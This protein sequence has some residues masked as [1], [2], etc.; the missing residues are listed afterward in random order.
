MCLSTCVR[1]LA[2]VLLLLPALRAAQV[3]AVPLQT[4]SH[5][6]LLK[7]VA[8]DPLTE[9]ATP[10]A[11]LR[12][13]PPLDPAT[14]DYFFVQFRA[15][16]TPDDRALLE[17][18]GVEIQDYVPHDAYL[19]RGSGAQRQALQRAAAVRASADFHPWYRLEPGLE[20]RVLEQGLTEV[21]VFLF[22]GADSEEATLQMVAAGMQ[23][24]EWDAALRDRM[25]VLVDAEQLVQLAHLRDVQWVQRQAEAVLRNDQASWVLQSNQ[26][27]MTP[28][29]DQ[30][31]RGENMIVGHIDGGV[32]MDSCYFRDPAVTTPGPTHR[33]MVNFRGSM[34][35]DTHGTHTAGTA[36]GDREPIAGSTLNNGIA[37]HARMTHTNLSLINTINLFDSLEDQFNDGALVF[38]NSWGNDFSTS[39][40]SWPRDIDKFAWLH[41][42][43]LPIWSVTNISTLR[44]PENAKNA[45]A[46]GATFSPNGQDGHCFGGR[47]PTSDGRRKPEVYAVGCS[48]DS[49]VPGACTTGAQAGTS[50]AAP[51]IAGGAALT[52]QYFTEGWYPT[53][54]LVPAH[55][56]S[57]SAALVKA[58][59]VNG[60][61]D[62]TGISGYPSN[63]EG[64]GR[65]NLSRSLYLAGGARTVF[66]ADPARADSFDGPGEMH[67]YTLRVED[68]AQTLEVTMCFTDKDA[69]LNASFTPVNDI[70][71]ELIDPNGVVYLGNVFVGG[72]SATG[73]NPDPLNNVERIRLANPP[74]G[75]YTLNIH[76]TNVTTSKNQNYALVVSGGLDTSGHFENYGSGLAGAGGLVPT[77]TGSGTPDL[78]NSV[79]VTIGNAVGGAPAQLIIG[80]ERAALPFA[81]GTLNVLPPIIPVGLRLGGA[82][83]VPGAGSLSLV[84]NPLPSDLAIVS[85]EI[86]LQVLILDGAAPRGIAMTGGLA[87]II[88]Q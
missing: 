85:L 18:V 9:P 7:A 19:V 79:T 65:A 55:G 15:R 83:G 57:P 17:R 22:E 70:D 29:W 30:G 34:L 67:Q 58:A 10:P 50:M 24:R 1:R 12:A 39:Y 3:P 69:S 64:W 52:V 16:I 63:T 66:V 49:A 75:E 11:H 56:F 38:T 60:A 41:P 62:M 48:V 80:F 28:F 2:A 77:L 78:G 20:E 35:D 33:K 4:E 86:D 84:S 45:L 59:L 68:S 26:T 87:V 72:F 14:V 71:V 82:P 5:P 81:G 76:A 46:V 13:D 42:A 61:V 36:V 53:G 32:D 44:N 6:L 23:L 25:H 88:G 31:L 43:A 74:L 47:G 54:T 8:F 40:D 21:A 27:N 51:V 37:Y 73:G